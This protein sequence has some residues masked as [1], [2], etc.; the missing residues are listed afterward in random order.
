MKR[1]DFMG[2]LDILGYGKPLSGYT[3]EE[4]VAL[5]KMALTLVGAVVFG[6][7]LG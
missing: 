6:S 4:R 3:R 5:V 2:M 1:Q 7:L